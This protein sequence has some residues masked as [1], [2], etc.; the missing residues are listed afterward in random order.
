[1]GLSTAREQRRGHSRECVRL[2]DNLYG[3]LLKYLLGF[4]LRVA[5]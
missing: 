4:C 2:A 3:T 1:M 5:L